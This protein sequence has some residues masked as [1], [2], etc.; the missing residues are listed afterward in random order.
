MKKLEYFLVF[1]TGA[2]AAT[3]LHLSCGD[4]SPPPAD[5]ATE[6][7]CP[8]AEQPL[9][10]RL[11]RV[12][13]RRETPANTAGPMSAAC[14]P[15]EIAISGGCKAGSLDPRHVLNSSFAT[16]EDSPVA[17][18]CYFHNGTA[19]PVTSE[20]YVLCLKPAP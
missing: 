10:P 19:S 14:G 20:A 7:D 2:S 12:V 9:L 17:W 8:A 15:G 6:C 16:P 3:A 18:A 1:T 4:G 11:S 13:V 5:A